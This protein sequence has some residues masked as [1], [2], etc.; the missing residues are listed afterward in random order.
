[1]IRRM[2]TNKII[3]AVII[4]AGFFSIHSN[5]VKKFNQAPVNPPATNDIS[6][7]ITKGDKSALLQKQVAQ[8]SF[9]AAS[10]SYP[11]ITVDSTQIFQTIDGFGYTLTGGS[12]FLINRLA[13]GEKTSLLQELFGKNENSIGISYLRV[14]IGASDLSAE[15]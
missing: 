6:V 9:G 3:I 4:S 7:W 5:C 13:G 11:T 14:S 1:M 12:A 2:K 15:V 10:N 8:L